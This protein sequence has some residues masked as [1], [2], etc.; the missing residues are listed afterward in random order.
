MA[1][2]ADWHPG[3]RELYAYWAAKK[4]KDGLPS[5]KQVDP[6]DISKLL[7]R[8]FLADVVW[9]AG[10]PRIRFRLVGSTLVERFGRDISGLWMDEAYDDDYLQE[11]LPGYLEMVETRKPHYARLTA[12][13]ADKEHMTYCRLICPL[14]S[15]GQNIDMIIGFI[16]F[17]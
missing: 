2:P 8:I 6:I 15:D 10:K 11:V 5:R 9:D 14:A 3:A 1:P 13:Y 16:D 12:T 17:E 4:P 7:P